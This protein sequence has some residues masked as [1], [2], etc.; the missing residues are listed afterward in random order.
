VSIEPIG[1]F[2]RVLVKQSVGAILVH[3]LATLAPLPPVGSVELI[4]Q[5]KAPRLSDPPVG[6]Y[7]STVEG[8][9]SRLGK[10]VFNPCF[11]FRASGRKPRQRAAHVDSNAST[12][13]NHQRSP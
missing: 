12:V 7:G 4:R 6:P 13:W 5:A 2:T 3:R 11:D 10:M 8:L 1:G 9:P